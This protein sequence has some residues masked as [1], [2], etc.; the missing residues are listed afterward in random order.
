MA[1]L[2]LILAILSVII[3]RMELKV[4]KARVFSAK[5]SPSNN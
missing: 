3:V 5:Y 2:I 4:K 1:T